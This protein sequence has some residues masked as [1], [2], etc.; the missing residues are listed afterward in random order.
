MKKKVMSWTI[1]ILATGLLTALDQISKIIASSTLKDKSNCELIPGVLEFTY[2][3][4]RGAAFS[5]LQG[6]GILLICATILVLLFLLFNYNKIPHS[7]KYYPL[8]ILFVMLT[9][10]AIGNMID[11]IMN[12]YVVDFIYFSLINF[13]VFNVADCYVTVSVFLFAILGFFYY[14]DDD[15]DFLFHIRSK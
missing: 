10:G 9:T 12:G 8:R 5:S 3:E 4:N 1:F 15:L 2:H 11:R 14:K 13:P 7:K 6:K